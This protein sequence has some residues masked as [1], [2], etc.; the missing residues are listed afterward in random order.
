M[1]I[2]FC[3]SGGLAGLIHRCEIDTKA[4]PRAEAAEIENLV[5]MTGVLK[6]KFRLSRIVA[7]DILGYSIAVESS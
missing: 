6:S 7:C 1:K 4:L 3:Q 5:K 2:R